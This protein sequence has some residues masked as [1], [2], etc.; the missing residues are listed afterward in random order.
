MKHVLVAYATRMGSTAEIAEAIGNEFTR[1]GLRATVCPCADAG[2]V[3]P[4][5]AVVIGSGLYI[6]RWD[7]DAVAYLDAQAAGLSSRPTWLF[8]SGPCG[9]GAQHEQIAVP[10]KVLKRARRLGIDPPVT[11]GGRLERSSSTGPISRWM[12]TGALAGDFRDWDRIRAWAAEKA[13]QLQSP[14]ES[15]E[16]TAALGDL[17]RGELHPPAPMI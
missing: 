10:H 9:E 7:A 1:Q 8:Q 16:L 6:G 14:E 2:S 11:F 15:P 13:Q 4:F 3:L 12:A 17:H 5:D